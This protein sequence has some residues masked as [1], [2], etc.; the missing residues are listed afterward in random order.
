VDKNHWAAR[1]IKAVTDAGIFKGYEDSTFRPNE[2]ISRAE[3][4]TV[5]FKCLGLDEKKAVNQASQIQRDIG[6][7]ISLKKSAETR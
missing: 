5:I 3:L 2:T 7:R 6:R 4:A 1:Y